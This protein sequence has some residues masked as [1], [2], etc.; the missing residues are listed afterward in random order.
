[1]SETQATRLH[2][3]CK[4]IVL[5]HMLITRF[6][7]RI[8]RPTRLM[9]VLATATISFDCFEVLEKSDGQRGPERL[10]RSMLPS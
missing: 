10:L 4:I 1:M 2:S 5:K 6:I 3:V 9:S 7:V 8:Y